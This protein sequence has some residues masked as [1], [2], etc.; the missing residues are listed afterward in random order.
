MSAVIAAQLVAA[1]DANPQRAA[2]PVLFSFAC[3]SAQVSLDPL[4][5]MNT[6]AELLRQLFAEFAEDV[7]RPPVRSL[8][9]GNAIDDYASPPAFDPAV[10]VYTDSYFEA[11]HWGI[12]YLDAASWRHYLPHLAEFTL[13]HRNDAHV[14]VQTFLSSLRPPDTN[15]PRLAALS[16]TQE[17]AVSEFLDELAF[18]DPSPYRDFAMQVIEEWWGPRPQYREPRT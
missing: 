14:V 9:A 7:S 4:D 17:R 2:S 1:P 16:S 11:N 15:P 12:T 3:G 10:D 8:R 18:G 6:S 13:R 5:V